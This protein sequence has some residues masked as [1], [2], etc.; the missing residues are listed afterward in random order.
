MNPIPHPNS[1]NYDL[2][3]IGG[4]I[5]GAAIARDAA[6]RHFNV[7]LLEK[8]DFGSGASTKTSKLAH[9]G[10]RYLEHFQVHLVKESLRERDLLLKNAPHL[11]KPLPFLLPVYAN[12][13]YPLWQIHAGLFFYDCLG[14]SK[15]FQRHRKLDVNHLLEIVP[16]LN[17]DGLIGG[18]SYYDAQMQDHRIV[19]ENIVS[20]AQSGAAIRNYKEVIDLIIHEEKVCGVRIRDSFTGKEE[21]IYGKAVVNATGAWSAHISEKD[22]DEHRCLPAPTKGV[23]LVLPQLIANN[24][25]LLRTPQD[26]R[27]FFVLPWEEFSLV[28][29]TDTFFDGDP[30]DVAADHTDCRYLL[31]A[32]NAF[33]P[34]RHLKESSIIASFAGLRPLVAPNG[35]SPPSDIAREHAIHISKRGLITLLGGKYTTHRQIAEEVVNKAAAQL[36]GNH[37][38]C[39]TAHTPLPGAIGIE[40][41]AEIGK[42]LLHKGL[43]EDT[44]SHLLHTYGMCSQTILKIVSQDPRLAERICTKHPHILAELTYAARVEY[45]KTAADWFERRTDIAYTPCR[46]KACLQRVLSFF[47]DK[48][49]TTLT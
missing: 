1:E 36:E 45:A 4:G 42:Q 30:N 47:E 44:V 19:I 21:E 22:P 6:L 41:I 18:C 12:D 10:V 14:G 33:F 23:H 38:P 3:V 17:K 28:G 40:N 29:T 46:G 13:P 2:V 16:G 35:K 31:D 37:A 9:G 7:I 24:A 48:H 34:D 20:A 5:N 15:G 8:E 25:L 27:V 26:R 43:P 49:A 32:V 11:V 39:I